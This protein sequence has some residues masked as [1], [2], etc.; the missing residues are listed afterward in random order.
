[1]KGCEDSGTF[2]VI[3]PIE[4]PIFKKNVDENVAWE[5]VWLRFHDSDR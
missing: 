4:N 5:F 1:V 3:P 2:S